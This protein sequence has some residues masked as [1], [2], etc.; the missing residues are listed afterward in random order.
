MTNTELKLT[1][2]LQVCLLSQIVQLSEDIQVRANVYILEHFVLGVH[3]LSIV[4]T[5]YMGCP[6]SSG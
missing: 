1:K 5:A 4:Q 2:S 6:E 3:S